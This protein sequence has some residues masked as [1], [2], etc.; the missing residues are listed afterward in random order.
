MML[1]N[2]NMNRLVVNVFLKTSA[3]ITTLKK[4][5]AQVS[6][7]NNRKTFRQFNGV[8]CDLSKNVDSEILVKRINVLVVSIS[9]KLLMH[10]FFNFKGVFIFMFHCLADERVRLFHVI[11]Y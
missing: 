6:L 9:H 3:L 1:L 7:E 2:D 8:V 11:S 5:A 4:L 10:I